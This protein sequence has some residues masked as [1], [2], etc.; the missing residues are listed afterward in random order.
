M[1]VSLQL[2]IFEVFRQVLRILF[3]SKERPDFVELLAV[4]MKDEFGSRAYLLG[5]GSPSISLKYLF[6]LRN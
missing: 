2:L 1:N 5:D 4:L 3:F 6:K